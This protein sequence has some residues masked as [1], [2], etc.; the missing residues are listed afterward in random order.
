MSENENKLTTVQIDKATRALLAKLAET[1]FRPMAS[2]LRWLIE[3][4]IA[5]RAQLAL[6]M[7]ETPAAVR[8]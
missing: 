5:R 4:E 8:S 2:E 7:T 6:P 1:D 3:Q